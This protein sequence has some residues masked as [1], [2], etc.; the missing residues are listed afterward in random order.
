M[1]LS[2]S[3]LRWL[4]VFWLALTPALAAGHEADH[5]DG[6][7][8]EAADCVLCELSE[9]GGDGLVPQHRTILPVF[10]AQT[11][12]D[13]PGDQIQRAAL[14]RENRQRAPPPGN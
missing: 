14:T 6:V 7:I 4:A 1:G 12:L 13:L 10:L 9:R 11:R 8:G 5:L 2:S 3:L